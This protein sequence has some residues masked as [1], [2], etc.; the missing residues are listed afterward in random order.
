LANERLETMS[1]GNLVAQLGTM[2]QSERISQ[3]L[4][5][6]R[7]ATFREQKQG[8]NQRRGYRHYGERVLDDRKWKVTEVKKKKKNSS[9]A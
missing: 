4:T 8:P 1:P 7:R 2:G 6:R 9:R 5:E 3:G